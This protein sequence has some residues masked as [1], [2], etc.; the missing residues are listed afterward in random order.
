MKGEYVVMNEKLYMKT[1]YDGL[2]EDNPHLAF[3]ICIVLYIIVLAISIVIFAWFLNFLPMIVFVVWLLFSML[4]LAFKVIQVNQA[5]NMSKSTAFIE[6][7]DKLF[8]V[9]LMYRK[10]NNYQPHDFIHGVGAAALLHNF[11]VAKSVQEAEIE[12]RNRRKNPESFVKGLNSILSFLEK[13]PN[14]YRVLPN[15]KRSFL[16]NLLRYDLENGGLTTISMP[17]ADYKFLILKKP[18]I[19]SETKKNFTIS[20]YNEKDELCNAIFSNCYGDIITT[21]KKMSKN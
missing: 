20:F 6:K 11:K 13:K 21:I 10:D 7:D 17:D 2:W 18:K 9:Q 5:K 14:R 4:F 16:D 8:V 1:K 3:G 12:V 15:Y 19:L